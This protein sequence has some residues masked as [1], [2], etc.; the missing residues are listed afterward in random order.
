MGFNVLL[1]GINVVN[2]DLSVIVNN[3]VNVNI[4]GFKQLCVEFVDLF[5]FIS[6]GLLKNQIGLGVCVFNVV[7]QFIQGYNEQIGCSLDMVIFGEGFFIMN[8][9]GLC[10]YL[11]VGNFQ[12]DLVGYVVNLQGVCLQVFVLN[13]D[14][15]NFD[16][17]CLVDLQLLIIDSLLKQISEVKVGFILLVNVK[18][19]IVVMFDLIDFNSYNYF[20]GGI[21]VYDLLGVSYIQVLYFVKGVN[22][23]EWIVYN[24]VD[25]QFVGILIVVIFDNSGK[26]IVLVNGKV[27]FGIFILIMGV[28]QLNMMLDISG[29][30]QYGEKFVLCNI[31]QDG[32]V[33]GKFN[34]IIVFELGVVYVCYFN[35]DDKLLGQVVLIIFNNIQGLELKGNNLWVEIFE[36]GMLCIGML[37]IFNFGK[38]QVGLLEVL[39]VDFI[40]Q[41][42]N[43]II[44]QCNFQVNVQMIIMQDQ[45]IQIVINIC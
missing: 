44:V 23:N 42:V 27:G 9:N 25:G 39:I 30:I 29:L 33:V 26:L 40:E 3:V 11:C 2:I 21:I 19:F 18:Q 5:V 16:V 43:M 37:D 34:E 45:I 31:Q 17:G 22:F 6:Y 7:Q 12:I 35:G 10:V 20:S 8:M 1:F 41:L 28:G 24:Y 15:I 13:V 14:G 32:Y 38:I 4:I 36:L